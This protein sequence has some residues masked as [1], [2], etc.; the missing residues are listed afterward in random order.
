MTSGFGLKLGQTKNPASIKTFWR[1]RLPKLLVPCVLVN[2]VGVLIALFK[3]SSISLLSFIAINA[4]VRWLLVCYLIFWIVYRISDLRKSGWQQDAII[5][6]FVI[7]FS[8]VIYAFREHITQTTWCPEIFGFV[9][10]VLL[11]R[12]KE[13]FSY[14]MDKSWLKKC[15]IFCFVAGTLGVLYLKFKPVVF[16]GDYLLKILLGVAIITFMLAL[17]AR[18]E[19]GNKISNFLG[20][21]SFE[22]YLLHGTVFGLIESIAPKIN[23]GIF[24]VISIILDF[25]VSRSLKKSAR[26]RKKY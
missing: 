12:M 26:S 21:I 24:I 7:S 5:C 1:R 9:W 13:N 17:N 22:I 23:S 15:I 14:W 11:S 20:S 8:A 18:L 2:V 3:G 10:G 25:R 4:W 19:I 6:A 16:F